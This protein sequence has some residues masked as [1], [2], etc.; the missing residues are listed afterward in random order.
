M[1]KVILMLGMIYMSYTTLAIGETLKIIEG[2]VIQV[3]GQRFSVMSTDG[4][5]KWFTTKTKLSSKQIGKKVTGEV[6][7]VGD[8]FRMIN[9]IFTNE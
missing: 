6:K 4:S 3:V 5:E 1:K 9:P 8:T 7:E 2:E